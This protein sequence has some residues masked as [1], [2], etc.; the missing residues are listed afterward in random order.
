[1]LKGLNLNRE[2]LYQLGRVRF[3][4]AQYRRLRKKWRIEE[5]IASRGQSIFRMKQV[6]NSGVDLALDLDVKA[7]QSRLD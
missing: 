6:Q 5:H 7:R 4:Q 2:L 3:I 1:M